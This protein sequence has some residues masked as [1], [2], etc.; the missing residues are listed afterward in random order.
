MPRTEPPDDE[1]HK[2]ISDLLEELGEGPGDT[3][4]LDAVVDHFGR[5]AFGALL[6]IFAVPNLLPL[7][8][9]STAV[10][11]LP[12]VLIAPQ[13]AL[14][15]R[16]LWLPRALGRRTVRRSDLKRIFGRLLPRQRKIERLLA[17]RQR[18]IFGRLGDRLI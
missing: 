3:I 2:P 17:P 11:G 18:W 7:P 6:F 12:L 1:P 4:V 16:N 8:P 5:R 13:L 10:L 9:G 14:G 15:V